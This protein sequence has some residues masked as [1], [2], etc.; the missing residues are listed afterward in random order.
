MQNYI[1]VA[2]S[3]LPLLIF[4]LLLF[5]R[6]T[7]L[8]KASLITLIIYT[9][10]IIFY[11]KVFPLALY[12]SY[13]KGFFVAFD[14]F[15]IIF[16]AIFFLRILED[17]NVIKNISYYL[18]S[19]S[20]DYRVKTIIIAWIFSAFLE[21]TAGFGVPAAVAV[22]LLVGIGLTPIQSLVAGLLGNSTAGIFGA[23]G[24]PIRVGFSGLNTSLVP[25]TAALFSFVG[26]I[27]P[28]FMLW[29][30][31]KN[32]VNRKAEFSEALPFAIWS[33]FL[34]SLF[35]FFM[36]PFGQE[37]PS[38]I[39]PAITLCAIVLSVKFKIFTPKNNISLHN[40][41]NEELKRTMSMWKSFSPYILLIIFLILGKIL[42]G[43]I[44]IPIK[45][46]FNHT[47]NLFNPGF[48]FVFSGLIISVIWKVKKNVLKDS[49]KEAINGVIK[50]FL[51]ILFMSIVAQLIINSG[52]NFSGIPAIIKLISNIFETHLLPLFTPFIGAF[53][54]FITGS[55]T[56]SNIMFGNILSTAGMAL[57]FNNYSI[58]SICVVGG[59]I[60]NMIAL[61]D[62]LTAEAVLREKNREIEIVKGVIIPCISSLLIVGVIGLIIFK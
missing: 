36:V 3:I 59:A 50:P 23:A 5:I 24:T 1:P 42:L 4:I 47:F 33:G 20:K 9:I 16:G 53:G 34:L 7:T 30:I 60:G 40:E 6:K 38:I 62:M 37:F 19:F 54:A 2:L 13:G 26:I 14:I 45:L 25:E 39:G 28:I 56:I 35:S 18:E 12:S 21:G 10:F 49:F 44:G 51:V 15:I 31:T 43:K 22:P 61:A 55:V 41:K 52:N 48:I 17:L 27:I 46:G 58:L 57:G 8:F 32:R 11:W 29:F